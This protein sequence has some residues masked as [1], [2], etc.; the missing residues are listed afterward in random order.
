V[1]ERIQVGMLRE[2]RSNARGPHFRKTGRPGVWT[3]DSA[4]REMKRKIG[5]D[6][7]RLAI[8]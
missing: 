6:Q 4:T 7:I 5:V 8:P 1:T 2:R 3:S